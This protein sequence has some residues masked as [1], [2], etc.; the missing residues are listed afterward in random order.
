MA[1]PKD[2]QTRWLELAVAALFALAGAIVMADSVRVGTGW[3]DEG[4]QAGYFPFRIACMLLG[5]AAVVIVQTLRGWRGD[6]GRQVFASWAEA[7]LML[8]M[9]LPMVA[10]VA[11]LMLLG[12]YVASAVFIAAFM[13][14][15]GKYG[16]LKAAAVGVGVSAALFLLF[17][18][19]FLVPLPKGPI[20]HLLGY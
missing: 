7:R 13:V 9:L 17:E 16:G 11:A 1:A 6:G 4:P 15:Q 10:Y 3:G 20:E 2:L 19:W 12:L 5:G 18:V 8:T 14:W